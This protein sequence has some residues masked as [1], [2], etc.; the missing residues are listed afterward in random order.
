[1]NRE[2]FMTEKKGAHAQAQ[3]KCGSKVA[4]KN[5][6]NRFTE[7]GSD[8]LILADTIWTNERPAVCTPGFM[9]ENLPK[10]AETQLAAAQS[11]R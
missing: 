4:C 5:C 11:F 7:S 2:S 3:E 9:A 10:N 8:C 6:Q 1:M